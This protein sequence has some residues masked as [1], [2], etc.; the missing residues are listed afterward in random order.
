MLTDLE[1]ES[2]ITAY[3][4]RIGNMSRRVNGNS[5]DADKLK[6]EIVGEVR[7]IIA[8][9]KNKRSNV[10]WVNVV[11]IISGLFA[12]FVAVWGVGFKIIIPITRHDGEI[13]EVKDS[14]ND[15]KDDIEDV[16]DDIKDLTV[17]V[18][19]NL[20]NKSKE[21][22]VESKSVKRITFKKEYA[23]KMDLSKEDPK[24]QSSNWVKF[25]SVAEDEEGNEYTP[26]DLYDTTFVTCYIEEG[27][28]VYFL[29]QLN[30][31][32]EWYGKCVLNVYNGKQLESVLEAIY[33]DGKLYSYKRISKE[34]DGTWEVADKVNKGKYNEG[35]TWSYRTENEVKK[36]ISVD[37]YDD[38]RMIKFEDFDYLEDSE[39]LSY[40]KGKT[41]NSY[42]NEEKQDSYYIEYFSRDEIDLGAN[43]RAIKTF[44]K[45]NFVNGVFSDTSDKSWYITREPDTT[46]MFYEGSFSNNTADHKNEK[47]FE[48]PA[49]YEYIKEKLRDKGF[50]EYLNEFLIDY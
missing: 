42:F 25:V 22:D 15:I 31:N 37:D 24:P 27:K 1:K 34:K 50:S 48:N 29:G 36:E 3:E 11:S 19:S 35:E 28:E 12:V 16:S 23:P 14:V 13:S 6:E 4:K 26:E 5:V 45:G 43:K 8:E 10:S 46:Y 38:S 7:E 2:N 32:N 30:E 9:S 49:D 47:E 20:D 17:F 39:L 21:T 40:Y 33:N 18:Y 44:Y 41:S